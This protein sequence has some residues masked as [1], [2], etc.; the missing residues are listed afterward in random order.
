LAIPRKE[1][2]TDEGDATPADF[3]HIYPE[4]FEDNEIESKVQEM[5]KKQGV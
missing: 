3:P 4:A 5:L 2:H 1:S